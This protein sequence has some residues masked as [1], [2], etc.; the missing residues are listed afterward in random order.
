[1]NLI[2]KFEVGQRAWR[3]HDN[4]AEEVEIVSVSAYVRRP[5]PNE[6][7]REPKV[8]VEYAVESPTEDGYPKVGEE[9]LFPTKKDLLESL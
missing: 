8:I 9:K 2:T 7:A 4:K 1:M 3:I 5:G 6:L